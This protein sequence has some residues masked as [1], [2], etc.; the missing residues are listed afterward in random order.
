LP[1]E[2]L[3]L[4]LD[5]AYDVSPARLRFFAVCKYTKTLDTMWGRALDV[6]VAPKTPGQ[7]LSMRALLPKLGGV[8]RRLRWP[9]L[10]GGFDLFRECLPLLIELRIFGTAATADG[11]GVM[12]QLT[13]LRLPP[14]LVTLSLFRCGIPGATLAEL[15]PPGLRSLCLVWTDFGTGTGAGAEGS[16]LLQAEEVVDCV[17]ASLDPHYRES[18]FWPAI[19]AHS[20]CAGPG[21]VGRQY[22]SRATDLVRLTITGGA[23]RRLDGLRAAAPRL[24][25]LNLSGSDISGDEL[26]H[27]QG[28]PLRGLGLS[29]CRAIGDDGLPF[30]STLALTSLSLRSTQVT[31]RGLRHL[32]GLPLETL[33]LRRTR[34]THEGLQR[35]AC[36]LYA[37]ARDRC[38][39]PPNRNSGLRPHSHHL[40]Q[41]RQDPSGLRSHVHHSVQGRQNPQDPRNPRSP[42]DPRYPSDPRNQTI[43]LT[44]GRL[45]LVDTR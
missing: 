41:D 29:R 30:L 17:C 22:V 2:L 25:L 12:P 39:Q 18:I 45:L 3:N 38:A 26:K 27:L 19:G 37:A 24:E 35:L 14:S 5:T 36:Q 11:L 33:D 28:L 31:D 1:P 44:Y 23:L 9:A 42:R 16:S 7:A 40:L 21:C 8:V 4:V 13:G 10:A 15:A 6:R 34:A 32:A 43:V 20:T